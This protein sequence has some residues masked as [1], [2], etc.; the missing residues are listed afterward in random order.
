MGVILKNNAI[1]TL[2]ST[3]TVGATTFTVKSGDGS[4]FPSPTG[5]QW[6]PVTLIKQDG[7][8]EVCKCTSRSGDT[9]TV[10]R[11]QEGTSA[12]AWSANERIELRLTQAALISLV[13]DNDT[14]NGDFDVLGQL[15][16]GGV[17]VTSLIAAAVVAASPVG[18][19]KGY[20]GRTAPA[21]WIMASG[22]TIGDALSGATERANA[23]TEALFTLYWTDFTN[24]EMPIYD[25]AGVLSTRGASAAADFAAHKRMSIPDYRGRVGV[26]QDNMGGTSAGLL[27]ITRSGTT[28]NASATVTGLASTSDL[29]VGMSVVG[30]TVPS[31]ITIASIDSASQITLSTGVGVTAGSP[32]LRFYIVDGN[33]IGA[34]GGSQVHT[35]GTTQIPA[36]SHQL[37]GGSSYSL[38][39]TTGGSDGLTTGSGL[40]ETI[41]STSNAGGGQA[42]QNVQPSIV[43]MA[44]IKL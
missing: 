9:L 39:K 44:I 35:L 5:S 11:A 21:G 12:I 3:A 17:T 23:D 32:S 31:G 10:V 1:S 38:L 30:S 34:A 42:H 37:N 29:A 15:K 22:R 2:A 4:L 33:T 28:S 25:S 7:S 43:E 27:A 41:S 13:Q 6:F 40:A 36:H 16:I 19:R 20:T 24:A 8:I 14:V 18:S 26:G